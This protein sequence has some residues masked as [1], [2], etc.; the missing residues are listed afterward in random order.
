MKFISLDWIFLIFHGIIAHREN[1]LSLVNSISSFSGFPFSMRPLI[2]IISIINFN[3]GPNTFG[4]KEISLNPFSVIIVHQRCIPRIGWI[5]YYHINFILTYI[6]I[7][8]NPSMDYFR[9]RDHIDHPMISNRL[10]FKLFFLFK[11]KKFEIKKIG[12]S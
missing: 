6:K 2:W 7:F 1:E 3:R 11:E 4:S 10:R 5:V 9:F 8:H 12:Y